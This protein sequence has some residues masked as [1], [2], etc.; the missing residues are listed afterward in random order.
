LLIVLILQDKEES[1]LKDKD[2]A[3][4]KIK[5]YED[6]LK[7]AL[8]KLDLAEYQ[9]RKC[10]ALAIIAQVVSSSVSFPVYLS[11]GF[12]IVKLPVLFFCDE[13]SI[14]KFFLYCLDLIIY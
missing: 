2:E 11:F 5:E 6:K 10:R 7:S 9:K 12:S 4:A 14:S 13:F 3:L 8:D 1:L